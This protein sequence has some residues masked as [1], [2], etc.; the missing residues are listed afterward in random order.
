MGS[1][2]SNNIKGVMD[3]KWVR[4]EYSKSEE[5]K[6]EMMYRLRFIKNMKYCDFFIK[7]KELY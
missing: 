3:V 7:K 1:S 2:K 6:G 5:Y 4:I